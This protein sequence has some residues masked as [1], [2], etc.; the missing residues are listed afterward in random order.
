[1]YFLWNNRLSL[2]VSPQALFPFLSYILMGQFITD[3]S[4]CLV[5]PL[6]FLLVCSKRK[7][8]GRDEVLVLGSVDEQLLFTL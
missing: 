2:L 4:L 5:S 8:A 1:L 6:L 3:I 7:T